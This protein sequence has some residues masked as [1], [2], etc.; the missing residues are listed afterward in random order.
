MNLRTCRLIFSS[1]LVCAS[2]L[3]FNAV[4]RADPADQRATEFLTALQSD[5]FTA[6]ERLC[7][8]KMQAGMPQIKAAWQQETAAYGKLKSFEITSR[9]SEEGVDVRIATL[10]FERPSGLAAQ[11]AIDGDGNVSGLYFV[12]AETNSSPAAAKIADDRVNEMLAALRDGNFDGA[13]AH[14]DSAMKSLLGPSVLQAAWKER[15]AS[16]GDL[17]SW[18]IA[19]RTVIGGFLVRIV[20]CDFAKAPKAFALKISFDSSG[21]IGGFYFVQPH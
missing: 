10:N 7:S 18:Q 11:I 4:A 21:E 8:A 17:K 6:V 16:L 3:V 15:T 19:E 2:L 12:A 9:K 5:D 13:E 1:M 20:N 14:F